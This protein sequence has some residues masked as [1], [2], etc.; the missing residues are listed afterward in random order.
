MLSSSRTTTLVM[1]GISFIGKSTLVALIH[2]YAEGQRRAGSELFEAE[3]IRLN[4]DAD[5]TL[6]SLAGQLYRLQKKPLPDFAS[7]SSQNQAEELFNLLAETKKAL[8]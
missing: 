1:S 6:S 8:L 2:D 5:V 3:T 4:V 7:L